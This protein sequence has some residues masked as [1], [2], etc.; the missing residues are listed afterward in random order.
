M[1]KFW[2]AIES[3]TFEVSIEDQRETKRY[4]CGKE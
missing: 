4:H 2:V 1:A 3:K